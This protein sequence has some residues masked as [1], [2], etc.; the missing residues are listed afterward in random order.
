MWQMPPL[1]KNPA[2]HTLP[3]QQGSPLSPH[4]TQTLVAS[5]ARVLLSQAPPAQHSSPEPPQEDVGWQSPSWQV[6]PEQQFASSAHA[7]PLLRQVQKPARHRSLQQSPCAA[8]ALGTGALTASQ[9]S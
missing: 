4:R 9:L 5:Q 3:S 6:D 2:L 7:P 8:L 1:Q